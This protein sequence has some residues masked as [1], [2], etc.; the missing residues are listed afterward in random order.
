ME[1]MKNDNEIRMFSTAQIVDSRST[2][3]VTVKIGDILT[4]VN[5]TSLAR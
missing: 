3:K 4:H 2:E 5:G 1:K